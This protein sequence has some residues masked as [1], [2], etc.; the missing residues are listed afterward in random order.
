MSERCGCVPGPMRFSEDVKPGREPVITPNVPI[1]QYA[2]FIRPT[3][4]KAAVEKGARCAEDVKKNVIADF[5]RSEAYCRRKGEKD[6]DRMVHVSTFARIGGMIYMT[7]Y[8]NTETDAEIPVH[9]AARFAFCPEAD[10]ED[11]TVLE[12]QKVG[13]VVDGQTVTGV[14]D[15]IMMRKDDRRLYLMWTASTAQYY[16][17]YRIYDLAS[18]TLGPVCVNRF[19]VGDV[20]NDFST[21]GI[22]N[23][24][25]CSGIPYHGM[26]SDIG[27]MQKVTCR[28]EN[29]ETWYYTGAY[30]GYLNC[31]IKSRDLVTWEYV[32]SPDFPNN[33]LWENATW[34]QGDR[35]YYFVR[36]NE[37]QQGFLTRYDLRTGTWDTPVL[38]A[39]AQSRSD[40][41]LYEG[42]LYLVHAPKDRCGFGIVRV[43]M[44]DLADSRPV[45]VA[46]LKESL[47][48]PYTEVVGEEIWISYTVDRKH[49]RLS[50]FSTD[51]LKDDAR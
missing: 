47:F 43:G 11:L 3:D 35:I 41:F 25:T 8:A 2:A 40:F 23:A 42:Q 6:P 32:S 14:Y 19:R 37:C 29:G 4:D 22:S 31:I 33:S 10:P 9:Q 30:S 13:D 24:L 21:S 44:E 15:T 39:D 20:T 26:F 1:M 51:Y 48:Y 46:D 18:G 16:R 49:I 12:L 17:F 7:Y 45:L 27:I 36:Q 38:I 50:R 28:V 5:E 34:V